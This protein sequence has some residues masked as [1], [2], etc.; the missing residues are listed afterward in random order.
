LIVKNDGRREPYDRQKL[1]HGVLTAC[2]KR[3]ISQ[4]SIEAMVDSIEEDLAALGRSE[5]K[6]SYVGGL[7]LENLKQLDPMAY[8]RFAMVYLQMSDLKAV[9][10]HIGRIL[11]PA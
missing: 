7:V 9:Q 8:I 4:S 3:P 2:A 5:V 11:I 1:L 6:S 10:E